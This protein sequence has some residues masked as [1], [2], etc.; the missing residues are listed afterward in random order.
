MLHLIL[1]AAPPNPFLAEARVHQQAQ[2]YTRCLK[3]LEQA[4]AWKS[5][6]DEEAEVTL[7]RGLCRFGAGDELGAA[8][9]FEHALRISPSV[10]LPAWTSPR[11]REAFTAARSRAGVPETTPKQTVTE[12]PAVTPPLVTV[13]PAPPP[14]SKLLVPA[15]V[16]GGI[17]VAAL[18]VATGLGLHA[19]A[20]EG[21]SFSARFES[22]AR[23]AALG[24]RDFATAANAT[25]A[26]A[27]VAAL[28]A[29]VLL[30]VEWLGPR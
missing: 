23:S 20:L 24:A 25:F 15:L 3:R 1:L 7:L 27:A 10:A 16:T 5:S 13:E 14:R 17:S 8:G 21:V 29:G 18:G 6:V 4:A 2:D 12:P 19:R 28:T 22:D 26:V 30:L 9:D 11:I